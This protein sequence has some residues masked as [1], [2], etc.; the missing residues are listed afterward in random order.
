MEFN[1]I[2]W[3]YFE[4]AFLTMG[5]AGEHC[6]VSLIL[7]LKFSHLPEFVHLSIIYKFL[8]EIVWV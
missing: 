7:W 2:A 4:G 8:Q 6:K 3:C 5:K 1:N